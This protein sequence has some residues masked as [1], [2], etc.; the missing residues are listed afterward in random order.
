MDNT[1]TEQ[2]TR[3]KSAGKTA[4][5]IIMEGKKRKTS[6]FSA[7]RKVLVGFGRYQEPMS[8]AMH[9]QLVLSTYCHTLPLGKHSNKNRT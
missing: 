1:D 2:Q 7:D 8:F 5:N 4:I 6:K 9:S 3:A